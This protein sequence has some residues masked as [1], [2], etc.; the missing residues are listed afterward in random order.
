MIKVK[1]RKC[2]EDKTFILFIYLLII[3]L[4]NFLLNKFI[5]IIFI[6]NER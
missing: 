4:K 3:E 6:S 2:K 1:E 5:S